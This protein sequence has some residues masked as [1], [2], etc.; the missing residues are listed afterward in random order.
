M[1]DFHQLLQVPSLEVQVVQRV[2]GC[3]VVKKRFSCSV[4]GRRRR[5]T[6]EERKNQ[7]IKK[8]IWT[9][10]GSLKTSC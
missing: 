1:T 3:S 7:N 10:L 2:L 4:A 9:Q 5:S 6:P 8:T